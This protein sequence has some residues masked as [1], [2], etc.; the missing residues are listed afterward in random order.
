MFSFERLQSEV[1]YCDN[2]VEIHEPVDDMLLP[3]EQSHD[4]A[5]D[6]QPSAACFDNPAYSVHDEAVI[7]NN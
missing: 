6:E 7:F 4:L 2:S 1:F 5:G 3:T